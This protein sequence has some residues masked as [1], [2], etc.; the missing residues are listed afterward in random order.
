MFGFFASL[1][2]AACFGGNIRGRLQSF[3]DIHTVGMATVAD[4]F[5]GKHY[6]RVV[7]TPAVTQIYDRSV[8]GRTAAKA[9]LLSSS[10]PPVI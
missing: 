1:T 3:A 10:R 4:L 8:A 7:S 6:Q 2:A 5:N 9:F